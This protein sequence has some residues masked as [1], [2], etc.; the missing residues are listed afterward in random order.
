MVHLRP[1]AL[2][3]QFRRPQARLRIGRLYTHKHGTT[4]QLTCTRAC[5]CTKSISVLECPMLQTMQPFFILSRCSLPT[6]FLLPADKKWDEITERQTLLIIC[7][8]IGFYEKEN[9]C[10]KWQIP[11]Q[12]MTTS[13]CRTTSLSLITLNPSMLKAQEIFICLFKFCIHILWSTVP[14]HTTY[15]AWRAQI[16]SASV[17]YTMAPRAFRAAQQPFPTYTI[18]QKW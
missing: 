11:V 14:T 10:W 5:V 15:Q 16:G 18:E 9:R 7:I 2:P 8:I 6:T 3:P 13:T 1:H 17:T 12:V 4:H